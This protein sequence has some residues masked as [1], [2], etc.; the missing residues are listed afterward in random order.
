MKR[1]SSIL[2]S[3][4]SALPCV[5]T[6]SSDFL[7]NL[8]ETFEGNFLVLAPFKGFRGSLFGSYISHLI[9]METCMASYPGHFNV[10]IL[11]LH[12]ETM[13]ASIVFTNEVKLVLTP[14]MTVW[15]ADLQSVN[16]LTV[17]KF[18]LLPLL[19]NSTTYS[20]ARSIALS[21]P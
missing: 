20:R 17:L 4:Q 16:V 8:G 21:S 1:V 14:L 19:L 11:K 18:T 12:R 7:L 2:L 9:L 3:L 13:L 15:R 6:V 10:D 5:D